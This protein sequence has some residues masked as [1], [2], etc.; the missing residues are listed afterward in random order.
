MLHG[1]Q[2]QG[3]PVASTLAP[4]R[5]PRAA[6]R[7]LLHQHCDINA[8]PPA[9]PPSKPIPHPVPSCAP[10]PPSVAPPHPTPPA[11]WAVVSAKHVF[12]LPQATPEM[13]ALMT[14]GLTASIALEQAGLVRGLQGPGAEPGAP[15]GAKRIPC[16]VGQAYS[17]PTPAAQLA[18]AL[19]KRP[20]PFYPPL[21]SARARRCL[22][23]R[24]WA[25]RASWRCS[26]RCWQGVTW[27]APAAAAPRQSCSGELT[28]A[29]AQLGGQPLGRMP[30]ATPQASL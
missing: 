28:V 21:R 22:S 27:W 15:A 24:L 1:R 13:V 7:L 18:Q 2:R 14:S 9:T 20:R 17:P 25:A 12:P 3:V 10:T 23:P 8:C 11:E 4:W 5:L 30:F 16:C 19:L 29:P 6:P 26:W